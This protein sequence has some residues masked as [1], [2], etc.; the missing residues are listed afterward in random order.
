[1]SHGTHH[2]ASNFNTNRFTIYMLS[3][4]VLIVVLL[5]S[6]G[7]TKFINYATNP[8]TGTEQATAGS[9]EQH[10]EEGHGHGGH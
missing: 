2:Q 6:I 10:H 8:K 5:Y 3:T 1:M 9:A 7:A 4:I